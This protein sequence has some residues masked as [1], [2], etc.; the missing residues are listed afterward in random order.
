MA[1]EEKTHH[2]THV[3]VG[4]DRE[5]DFVSYENSV[6]LVFSSG[7]G[8]VGTGHLQVCLQGQSLTH[9]FQGPSDD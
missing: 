6:E 3:L 2:K 9:L 7:K 1:S 4:C 8:C 5:A